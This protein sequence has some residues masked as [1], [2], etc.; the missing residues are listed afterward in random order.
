MY[1][2]TAESQLSNPH[3]SGTHCKPTSLT[4]F[5]LTLTLL[6]HARLSF[7]VYIT[8]VR[9]QMLQWI[10]PEILAS[11]YLFYFSTVYCCFFQSESISTISEIAHYKNHCKFFVSN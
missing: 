3:L 10:L 9:D 7:L 2:Y 4:F 6:V 5:N 8:L 1:Y 11:I